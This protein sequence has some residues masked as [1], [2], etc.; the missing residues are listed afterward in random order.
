MSASRSSALYT[1]IIPFVKT[2]E[3]GNFCFMLSPSQARAAFSISAGSGATTRVGT[4]N[5]SFHCDE[6]LACFMLRL[7][8]KFRNAEIV[9]TRDPQVGYSLPSPS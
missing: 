6:A 2:P 7:T 8:E 4:H 5:G 3:V 1:R 9:R